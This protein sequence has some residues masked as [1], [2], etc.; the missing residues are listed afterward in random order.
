MAQSILSHT[1][2]SNAV[3]A[4]LAIMY[5]HLYNAESIHLRVALS[6]PTTVQT[7]SQM[8]FLNLD[9]FSHI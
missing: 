6:G 8:T 4:L 5:T 9:N 3:R 7:L 2:L 1:G